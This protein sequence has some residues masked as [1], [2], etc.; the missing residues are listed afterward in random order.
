MKW[1]Y[2]STVQDNVEKFSVSITAY[3]IETAEEAQVIRAALIHTLT[4]KFGFLRHST[5]IA[6]NVMQE[7]VKAGSA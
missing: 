2:V 3:D 7:G 1:L 5:N 6:P 4:D